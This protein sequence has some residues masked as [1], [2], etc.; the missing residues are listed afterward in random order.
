MPRFFIE[1]EAIGEQYASITGENARHIARSLRMKTGEELTVSDGEGEEFRCRTVKISDDRVECEI[2]SKSKCESEPGIFV[3]L[4]QAMPKSD[5]L[6]LIVQKSVELGV[7]EITPIITSRC[8]SRPDEKSFE[9]KYERLGKIAEEAAM[10]S[11]R[12]RIPKINKAL[13]F[14][15]C[16]DSASGKGETFLLYEK[17]GVSFKSLLGGISSG[18][19]S[20]II[21]CEGG[22]EE[23]E[24]AYASEKGVKIV[25][26]GKRILRTETAPLCALSVIMYATG[27]LE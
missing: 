24:V 27:N 23:S 13:D 16:I 18:T 20:I 17:N 6:E 11:G 4:Y 26:L 12:G 2:L 15:E 5:K 8:I 25:N 14:K 10:Q 19:V 22:F 7:G 3:S 21:G 9:K 1:K